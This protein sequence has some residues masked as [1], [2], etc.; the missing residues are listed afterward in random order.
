MSSVMPAEAAPPHARTAR[1]VTGDFVD[2]QGE[3]YYRIR[4]VDD[5]PPFFIS[6]VSSDDHW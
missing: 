1:D 6:V 3:R 5:M 2:H 4:N